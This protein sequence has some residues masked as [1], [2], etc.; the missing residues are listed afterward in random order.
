MRSRFRPIALLATLACLAIIPGRTPSAADAAPIAPPPPTVADVLTQVRGAA[1]DP[2][3]LDAA[4]SLLQQDPPAGASAD[5][6]IDFLARRAQAADELGDLPRRLGDLRRIAELAGGARNEA[7]Q[8]YNLGL[9]EI[10]YGEVQAGMAALRR[11]AELLETGNQSPILEGNTHSL[12]AVVQVELGMYAEADGSIARS[13]GLLDRLK[14]RPGGFAGF[15]PSMEMLNSWAEGRLLIVRGK[16]AEAEARLRHAV[17]RSEESAR[18]VDKLTAMTA[19]PSLQSNML[20]GR[21]LVVAEL[22][23]HLMREG[24]LDEAELLTRDILTVNLQRAGRNSIR[25]AVTLVQLADLVAARGRYPESRLILEEAAAITRAI[26]IGTANRIVVSLARSRINTLLGLEQWAAVVA[27]SDGFRARVTA[28]LDLKDS[29]GLGLFSAGVAVAMV[30][31]GRAGEAATRLAGHI[32]G[33]RAAMGA[34]HYQVGEARGVLGMALAAEG[35]REA[36]LAEF[37]AAARVL[38]DRMARDDEAQ[39]RGMR[40]ILRREILEAYLDLLAVSA[41][42]PDAAD[43]A[44][45][46]ADA[47]H[48]GKT[49]QALA[50]SAAR[51]AAKQGEL[52]SLVRADQDGQAEQIALYGNLLRL[53]GL[54]PEKQL[55]AVMAGMRKRIETIDRERNARQAT[56]EQRFPAYAGLIHPKPPSLAEARAVLRPDEA[57]VTIFT[58]QKASY[59]WA[60]RPAGDIGFFR[61]PVDRVE[62]GKLVRS[63]RK[64]VDPGDVD[65]A[66]GLPEFDLAAGLRLYTELLQPVAKGWK[67]AGSLLVVANGSLSQV[68]FGLLPTGPAQPVKQAGMRY[69]QYRAVPWLIREL[70]ITQLPSV[71]SLLA[72]RKL[73]AGD[74]QRRAFVGFGDPEFQLAAKAQGATRGLRKVLPSLR[75]TANPADPLAVRWP[76]YESI[77]ALPDTRD[78]ILDLAKVLR[79]DPVRDVFLGPQASRENVLTQDLR[80]TR[81]VAFATHGLLPGEFPGVDQPALALANPGGGK[82]GLLTLEDVLG[83]KL[84]AD[85]VILSACNTAGGDGSGAEAVSGLGR[86]F[87]YAGTRALLATHWP[88]ESA[89]ARLLVTGAFSRQAASPDVSRAEALR[90]SMLALM[91][92]DATEDGYSHAH[93]MFWAPYALI[94]DGG[95]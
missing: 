86:G 78:E 28:R 61:A 87:F 10:V 19:N 66:S 65:I 88:V 11:V 57:L 44:F 92:T 49:Q 62:M 26:G 91:A 7:L 58:T 2:A 36:A 3:R 89:S 15:I 20:A 35:R 12:L 48:F 71:N 8:L 40:A 50:Q 67:G 23:N 41:E 21:N 29:P 33:L 63:I 17:A 73:P 47:L 74:P 45:R 6:Q 52:G 72:L 64:A 54:P 83:L 70:A 30:R 51:A 16:W 93:P 76:P 81:I 84:D 32:D 1:L 39:A 13:T 82:H 60:F 79:A 90:Q 38:I 43:R 85:W 25:T 77:P 18:N 56:I 22:A 42:L 9:A 68:P 24:R 95:R 37:A 75:T 69:A 94:G 80:R 14:A 55:P 59:V 27:E 5:D 46:I 31:S 53:A 34:D 4:K